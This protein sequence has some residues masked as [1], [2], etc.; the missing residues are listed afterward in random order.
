MPSDISI[1]A[2]L[3]GGGGG[4]RVCVW[5]LTWRRKS[6][7][8]E[9]E[10]MGNGE[11]D[12]PAHIIHLTHISHSCALTCLISLFALT[13]L[14]TALTCSHHLTSHWLSLGNKKRQGRRQWSVSNGQWVTALEWNSGGLGSRSMRRHDT[15]ATFACLQ[16]KLPA[17]LPCL[18]GM[19]AWGRKEGY[20]LP[21]E[22]EELPFHAMPAHL[23]YNTHRKGKSVPAFWEE[24]EENVIWREEKRECSHPLS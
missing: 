5:Y 11:T 3:G 24:E 22:E 4:R 2:F 10:P 18:R 15:S 9:G 17:A 19:H 1:P 16:K 12:L 13:S 20:P 7:Q 23:L 21:G 14:L 8:G 6:G